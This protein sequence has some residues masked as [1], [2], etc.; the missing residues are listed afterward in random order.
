MLP[1]EL[2]LHLIFLPIHITHLLKFHFKFLSDQNRLYLYRVSC[3]G[4]VLEWQSVVH[5]TL[6]SALSL[7]LFLQLLFYAS[8]R[9][10]LSCFYIESHTKPTIFSGVAYK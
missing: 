3:I 6:E 8:Q 1:E 9:R 2:F 5:A 10:D 4:L 7:D